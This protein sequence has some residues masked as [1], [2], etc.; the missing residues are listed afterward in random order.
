[1][2]GED[3]EGLEG[4]KRACLRDAME[5]VQQLVEAL[6]EAQPVQLELTNYK[7]S[8]TPFRNL[9]SLRPVHDSNGVYR[10][11]IGVQFEVTR[12]M[13][14]KSRL[15]KLDKLIKLLPSTIEVASVK[16]GIAHNRFEAAVE[17][18]TALEVKLETASSVSLF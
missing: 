7:R 9:L 4:A 12:D 14:L 2:P 5:A 17:T 15:S 18:N 16:T 10:F 8:G 6:R 13:S 1:M 11:C 3:T